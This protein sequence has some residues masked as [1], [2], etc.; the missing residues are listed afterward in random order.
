MSVNM[1]KDGQSRKMS[2]VESTVSVIAGYLMNV[3]IQFL[4][5]PVFG[6]NVPIESAFVI[7]VFI[8][9]IAFLKNYGV[10]RLF[11]YIHIRSS[12]TVI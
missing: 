3:A 4:L 8:T 9:G 2:A 11:N 10:R 7:S 6:I 12:S 1:S 5:Y